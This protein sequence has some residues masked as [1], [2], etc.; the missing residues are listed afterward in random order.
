MAIAVYGIIGLY[1]VLMCTAG[2]QKWKE[3]GFQLRAVFFIAVSLGILATLFISSK[4]VVL[5]MLLVEFGLLHILALAEG[6]GN[7]RIRYSHHLFRLF[8]H[9]VLLFMV[10]QFVK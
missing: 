8:F 3:Q 2:V 4:E 1:A 6:K 7:G 9:C 10:Y 5:W